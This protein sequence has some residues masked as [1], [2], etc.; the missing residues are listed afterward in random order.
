MNHSEIRS[1][2]DRPDLTGDEIFALA[3]SVAYFFQK[4]GSDANDALD[5]IIR[6][7]DQREAYE[8]TLRGVSAMIDAIAR[9]A[10]LYPYIAGRGG[11]RDELAM[12]LMRAPGLEDIIFHI[13]QALIFNKLSE[14]RSIILSAPTSFGK[15][16]LIDALIA[17]KRPQT[18][19][20]VVPTIALLD[21]FRRRMEKR[22]PDYQVITRS[23]QDRNPGRAIFIGTQER[24]LERDPIGDID[25]F[26]V[27]EF[28][29]LDLDRKD[30]RALALNAILAKYGRSA[31]QIYLLGPSIGDVP[32]IKHFRSDIE[33]IKTRYSPVTADIIDRTGVGP[34]PAQ[35]IKDLKSV[36]KTSSLIYV[37][38]PPAAASLTDELIK[39]KLRRRSDF[40]TELGAWLEDNFHPEWILAK[41]VTRGIGIHHGRIPRSVA[42]LMISLFNEGKLAA[43]VCTSSMIEGI[44]TA[45]EN[46]FI[47]DRKINTSKL[48]RFTFDNIKGR[49][50]RMFKHNIGKIYLYNRPP[51]ETQFDVRI[52]LFNSDELM[53]P[54]LLLQVEDD[55]L[56]TVARHRKR[57]ITDASALPAEILSR[58]AEFGVDELNTLADYVRSEIER[59]GQLLLWKGIPKYEQIQ[60]AFELPW[61]ILKFQK[62]DIRSA[63]Q[64]ALYA[65]RLRRNKTMRSYLDSLVSSTG[66]AAQPEIDKCFNFLRGA[67]YTF[68]Q[69]L[70]ATNDVID[71]VIGEGTVNYRVYASELQ[72]L[73]LPGELRALDEYGVP[74]PLI[75]RFSRALPVDDVDASRR[76]LQAPPQRLLSMMSPFETQLLAR[77]LA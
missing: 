39:S 27:D 73:F 62:H 70:R 11:W 1:A 4:P 50:G 76:L 2:L 24:L 8:K 15:S 6:L 58:W 3:R 28:Y 55:N 60:A 21:E 43:I 16:L 52:P 77:G 47:Y 31:K 38:S 18:V 19:L 64:L 37:R 30:N 44:N 17:H 46:V 22:F 61:D 53:T 57:A 13:E 75:R 32:N 42:Q 65:N 36:R 5:L 20:A 41:S 48:D 7:I 10:G 56:T 23:Q 74:L 12:E 67:E 49:A 33:L 26:I 25:L 40:C 35:L 69:V 29:K 59:S 14:G 45:A 71:A 51:D 54:E 34:S 68:P 72:N 63:K 66:L 9:E